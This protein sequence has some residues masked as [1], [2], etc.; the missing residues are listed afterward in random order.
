MNTFFVPRRKLIELLLL[1]I[2][3]GVLYYFSSSVEATS[4][5]AFGYIW[6]WTASN[7]IEPMFAN[8][9]YR[10]SLLKLVFSLQA[11]VLTPVK[12][13]PEIVK[14]LVKVL[15]AGTFWLFVTFINE[16]V[17]PWWAAYLGSLVFE[18]MQLE[19]NLIKRHKENS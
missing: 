11:F 4:L 13:A 8:K 9:R 7:D 1:P 2:F 3:L 14:R 12:N 16:S 17:M 18:I 15:P 5:F 19:M 6:N 10:M